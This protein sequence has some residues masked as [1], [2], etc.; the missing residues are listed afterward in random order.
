[1][2]S[3]PFTSPTPPADRL[4]STRVSNANLGRTNLTTDDAV[5]FADSDPETSQLLP[6]RQRRRRVRIQGRLA[7]VRTVSAANLGQ[8]RNSSPTA[9]AVASRGDARGSPLQR[10]GSYGGSEA[11]EDDSDDVAERDAQFRGYGIGGAGNIRMRFSSSL[12]ILPLHFFISRKTV[13][14]GEI[15]STNNTNFIIGRPTD[16]MGAPSSASP[17]LLSLIHISSSPPTV[18]RITTKPDTLRW[19][20]ASLLRGLRGHKTEKQDSPA[21][22]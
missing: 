5:L 15:E 7:S 3:Q 19:R 22:D 1:M 4:L 9:Q 2:R 12:S 21:G 18:P 11:D 10:R 13:L 20:V 8:A 16:I 6:R 17:S 14:L